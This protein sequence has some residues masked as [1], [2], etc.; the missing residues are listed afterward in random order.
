MTCPRCQ[1]LLYQEPWS[2]RAQLLFGQ[3]S[4]WACINCGNRV[5]GCVVENRTMQA[6][7]RI[8]QAAFQG[9]GSHA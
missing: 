8:A 6:A 4:M 7:D 1:G 9:K 2:H 3:D 5:D